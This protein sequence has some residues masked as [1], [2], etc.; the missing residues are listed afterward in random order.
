MK[1]LHFPLV[2]TLV[3]YALAGM[4][5]LLIPLPQTASILDITAVINK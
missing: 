3:L 1:P 4:L 2:S 5:T